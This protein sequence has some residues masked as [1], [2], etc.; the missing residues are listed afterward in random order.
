MIVVSPITTP[1]PWSMKKR[2]PIVAPGWIS[3]PVNQRA[4]CESQRDEAVPAVAP[5][6][7]VDP[8]GPDARAARG[9]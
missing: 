6:P 1:M 4:T 7:V 2:S 3:M 8:V 5:Q 9:S